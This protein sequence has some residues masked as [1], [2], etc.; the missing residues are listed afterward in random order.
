MR[1]N[2]LLPV[3]EAMFEI[4]GTV[5]CSAGSERA[6]RCPTTQFNGSAEPEFIAFMKSVFSGQKFSFL[7]LL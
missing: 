2:I 4:Q 6:F 1:R 5:Y 7:F 3:R